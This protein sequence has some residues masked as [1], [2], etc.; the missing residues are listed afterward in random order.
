MRVAT[1]NVQN[2]KLEPTGAGGK[3]RG[4]WDSGTPEEPSLDAA[5]RR[6]TAALVKEIDADIV[7]LQEVYD[8]ATLDHFHAAELVPAG[9]PAYGERICLPGND[10]RGLDV[11]L[12]SRRPVD[13]VHSYAALRPGDLGLPVP[14]GV[15]PVLP[16]FRRDCLMARIGPLTLFVCHFKSPYPDAG[17]AWVTRRLE[18]LATRR[19]VERHCGGRD[20]LLWLVLGDLN[21]PDGTGERAIAPLEDGFSVD[22][23]LR[24]A[25]PERWTFYDPPTGLYHRPDAML[26]SPALAAGWP[27]AVPAVVRK[28]LGREAT[29]FAGPRLAGVGRHRPHASDHAAVVIELA[30]L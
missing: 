27:D 20:D 16:V 17:I 30:G 24:V 3:L 10:G 29:R 21:E 19:L 8:Q 23:M 26:A 13:A 22:L 11:A 18:A 7:A 9:A 4:A 5:D 12:M 28:G 2:L 6:L 15:D 1:L 25:A 14:D